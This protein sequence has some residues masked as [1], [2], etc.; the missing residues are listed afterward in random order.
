MLGDLSISFHRKSAV[1]VIT[2]R[3]KNV[4]V[5]GILN[6]HMTYFIKNLVRLPFTFLG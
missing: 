4:L 1:Y 5:Y 2:F 3:H 6:V